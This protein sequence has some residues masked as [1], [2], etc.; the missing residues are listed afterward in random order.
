MSRGRRRPSLGGLGPSACALP[1]A[2]STPI[3]LSLG[4]VVVRRHALADAPALARHAND[5]RVADNLRDA[6]PHPYREA[7]ARAYIAAQLVE[8]VPT[9]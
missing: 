6:F 5:S 7:D 2:A 9:S 8:G 3:H 4:P 1:S